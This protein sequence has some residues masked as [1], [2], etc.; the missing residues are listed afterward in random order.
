MDDA[1]RQGSIYGWSKGAESLNE[2]N[3]SYNFVESVDIDELINNGQTSLGD[4]YIYN[5]SR[6]SDAILELIIDGPNGEGRAKIA[7]QGDI[8]E[9]YR[10]A[11]SI[12]YK[13]YLKQ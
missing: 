8:E 12:A 1:F 11:L 5:L 6:Q 4:F 2:N 10:Y 3:E 13:N 7:L 9:D